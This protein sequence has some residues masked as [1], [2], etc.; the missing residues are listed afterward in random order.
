[1]AETELRTTG[2][3]F[4]GNAAGSF[5]A[6]EHV[7]ALTLGNT[8][9]SGLVDREMVIPPGE[10][11]DKC[12]GRRL[13]Q[14][15]QALANWAPVSAFRTLA[16]IRNRRRNLVDSVPGTSGSS[17]RTRKIRATSNS[18][19]SPTRVPALAAMVWRGRCAR[20]PWRRTG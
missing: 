3:L 18:M 17:D 13:G 7:I 4:C 9:K 2:C 16:Q 1:M 6:E 10:V 11:C 14:R 20:S 5:T 15:D 8:L 12:N 19:C